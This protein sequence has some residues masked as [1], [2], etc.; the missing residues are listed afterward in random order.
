LETVKFI[1]DFAAKATLYILIAKMKKSR[2]FVW[3]LANLG[4]KKPGIP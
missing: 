3:Y 2:E 4:K 1:T